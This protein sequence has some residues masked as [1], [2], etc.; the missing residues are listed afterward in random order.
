MNAWAN[1]L[2]LEPDPRERAHVERILLR[3][4]YHPTLVTSHD[5]ALQ[6]LDEDTPP[7][8]LVIGSGNKADTLADLITT[9]RT[10]H[11]L[12][13]LPVL[14]LISSKHPLS[15]ALI[16]SGA[17]TLLSPNR[18][19]SLLHR[20]LQELLALSRR[21][22]NPTRTGHVVVDRD[23]YCLS[24]LTALEQPGER[25]PHCHTPRPPK[26][27]PPINASPY[28]ELG[29]VIADRYRLV[30]VAG[31][32]Q[33]GVVY[34]ATELDSRAACAVKVVSFESGP[35]DTGDVARIE[36]IEREVQALV[37]LRSPHVVHIVDFCNFKPG[38]FALVTELVEGD[39]LFEILDTKG[40]L[41]P[42]DAI[43]VFA[44][45][46]RALAEA[47][48]IGMIHRDLKPDNIMLRRLD[49]HDLFA[50]LLD[51]G[52]VDILGESTSDRRFFGSI[53]W[54]SPEQLVPGR[55]IDHR[56]DLYSLA[57]VLF[58]ALTGEPPFRGVHPTA[59]LSQHLKAPVPSLLDRLDPPQDKRALLIALDKLLTHMLAKKPEDRPSSCQELL[60]EL[61]A[62]RKLH[63]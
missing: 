7:D 62:I 21:H 41:D 4:Q 50:K 27:W 33:S 19:N 56:A 52:L 6:L 13:E 38:A 36:R 18:A 15:P 34:R 60:V 55:S 25:C 43:D 57:A 12:L 26:G 23:L 20:R 5:A 37:C 54:A 58:H 39:N 9:L 2:L 61:A 32:G 45:I 59:L 8:A 42:L 49:D 63:P 31:L 11:S 1:I 47:H 29:S 30:G 35:S 22:S 14:V 16:K 44:Q 10:T 53:T 3:A 28:P 51:F 17:N 24:C 40:P 48:A 46:A